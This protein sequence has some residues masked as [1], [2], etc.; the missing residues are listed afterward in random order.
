M[1]LYMSKPTS[2]KTILRME[3]EMIIMNGP[4]EKLS[5]FGDSIFFENGPVGTFKTRFEDRNHFEPETSASP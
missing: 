1:S 3:N 4:I 5:F 2:R